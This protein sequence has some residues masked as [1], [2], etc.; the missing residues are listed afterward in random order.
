MRSQPKAYSLE[1]DGRAL[2]A[3]NVAFGHLDQ[4]GFET[5]GLAPAQVHAQ[6]HFGPVLR[7]GAA[8]AGLDVEEGIVFVHFAG[9]HASELELGDGFFDAVEIGF[10]LGDGGLVVFADR[11]F[12]QLAG[13]AEAL[14]ALVKAEHHGFE[15]WLCPCPAAGRAPDRSRRPGFQVRADFFQ[16]F[17]F[18]VVVKDTSVA[19]RRAI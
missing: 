18:L 6:Q 17:A 4:L 1:T 13:V 14:S 10:D 2:D 7:L 16:F 3:G 15:S 5:L 19:V 12:E 11:E 9:K 8:G